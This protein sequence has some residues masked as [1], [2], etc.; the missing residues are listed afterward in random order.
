M[1]EPPPILETETI[2]WDDFQR[3]VKCL[4]GFLATPGQ[5]VA[6]GIIQALAWLA[7][8]ER[9]HFDRVVG[10]S[11]NDILQPLAQA[12]RKKT[13]RDLDGFSPP[14]Q[15]ARMVF[16]MIVAQYARKDLPSNLE[17]V[18]RYRWKLF[19]AAIVFTWGIGSAP[20]LQAAFKAVPFSEI[21]QPFGGIPEGGE[22]C[23]TRY[24]RVKILGLHFCGSA[25][26]GLPLIEGFHHLAVVYPVILWLAHWLAAGEGRYKLTLDDI[27]RAISIA[28]HNHSHS[29]AMAT[30]GYRQRIRSL[31]QRGDLERLCSQMMR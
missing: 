26:Y 13:P 7:L 24:F 6:L 29:P 22:E 18:I 4:D 11:A 27:H 31:V 28:D 25:C 20:P 9:G 19:R 17:T 12:V 2:P 10:E 14:G 1:V 8:I 30:A 15:F 5:P 21:E 16:R 3:F 23:L